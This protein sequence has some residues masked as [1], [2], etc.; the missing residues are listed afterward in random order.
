MHWT[1]LE[2]IVLFGSILT[3]K[4]NDKSDID[5][6]VQFSNVDLIDYFDNYKNFK[7]KVE[8]LFKRQIDLVEDQ[9]IKNSIFVK[10]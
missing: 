6:L 7:E 10:L 5:M 4:L 9:V 1:Q 2:K 8:Q 3:S